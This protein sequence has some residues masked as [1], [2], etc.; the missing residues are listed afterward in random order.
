MAAV[1]AITGIYP[2]LGQTGS[3]SNPPIIKNI[4]KKVHQKTRMNAPADMIGFDPLLGQ[5]R[6]TK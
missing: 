3:R 1:A 6:I 5:E 2:L 4:D